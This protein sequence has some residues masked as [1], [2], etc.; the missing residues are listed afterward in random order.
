M[1]TPITFFLCLGFFFFSQHTFSQSLEATIL[2]L[3]SQFWEVYNNCEVTK[4]KTFLTDDLEFYHDK[5]GLTETS[6]KLVELVK[7]GLCNDPKIKLRRE[8][9]AGTVKVFPLNNY[10]AII[11][12][13]HLFYLTENDTPERLVESAKFT[14]V[15]KNENGVW[16][17]S[18]VLSYDH[19]QTSSNVKKES[20]VLSKAEMNSLV[21]TYQAPK[22]G[23]VKI[24]LKNDALH[25]KAGNMNLELLPTSET[26]LLAKTAPI[27][28]E[29]TKNDTG[30][31]IQ[32]SVIEDGKIVEEAMRVE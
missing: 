13:E 20:V 5:G 6:D 32:F 23:T 2:K 26:V 11:T 18:R 12:G 22:T 16:R 31:A 25:M 7:N 4:F 8:A 27:R 10:G 3:D 9:V 14:H 17:M 19:Q 21:G 29:F 24:F 28:F 30:K 1:K 15:W